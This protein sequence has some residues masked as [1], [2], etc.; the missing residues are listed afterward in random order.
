MKKR[1]V[2]LI[3][4]LITMTMIAAI[5]AVITSVYLT[6]YKTFT[7]QLASST[8][9]SDAQT[10]LDALTTDIKNGILIEESY[11][12]YTSDND[13]II[14][15]VPAIDSGGNIVYSGSNMLFDRI[16][17]YYSG[18]SIHKIIYADPMSKRYSNSGKDVIL[19]K[20]ILALGF[21]YEPDATAA[22]LVTITI[23]SEIDLGHYTQTFSITG[24][25]RLR[26]HI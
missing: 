19:D 9:Q 11:D 6:G 22:T 7:T 8:I 12:S 3:E 16:I 10:I 17:Y 2:T 24:K 20:K 1:G 18:D 23:N 14:I 26:N 13:S 4:L 5:S 15:R 21:T 25:A